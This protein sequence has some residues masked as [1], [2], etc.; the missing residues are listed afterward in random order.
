MQ[1]L[2]MIYQNE[3]EYGKID[4]A[5]SKVDEANPAVTHFSPEAEKIDTGGL[6]SINLNL[7]AGKYVFICNVPGHYKLGM[8]AAFT[9][10]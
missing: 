4:A 2:L 7:P 6:K 3:A 9:V 8:H 10:N 5:T 1:Y